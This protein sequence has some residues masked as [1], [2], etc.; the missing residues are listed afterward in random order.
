MG[1]A[2]VA[3][4]AVAARERAGGAAKVEAVDVAVPKAAVACAV[5]SL[6]AATGDLLHAHSLGVRDHHSGIMYS[7]QLHTCARSGRLRVSTGTDLR[8]P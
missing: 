4:A 1:K 6:S 2:A 5:A 3:K 8:A 7:R